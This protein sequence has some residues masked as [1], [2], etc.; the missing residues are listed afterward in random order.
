MFGRDN[1]RTFKRVAQSASNFQLQIR[2]ATPSL[3]VRF[4]RVA[5]H[6]IASIASISSGKNPTTAADLKRHAPRSQHNPTKSYDAT[7]TPRPAPNAEP[8]ASASASSTT[9]TAASNSPYLDALM[10]KL[11]PYA[12]YKARS[13][14]TSKNSHIPLLQSHLAAHRSDGPKIVLLG[15]SMFERMITTGRT[16]NFPSRWPSEAMQ[17]D[18]HGRLAAFPNQEDRRLRGIF[19]AGVGGDKVQ[20]VIYRL[21]GD[22]ERGLLPLLPIL[23]PSVKV[24]VV[25]AGGNNLTPRTGWSEQDQ[26]MVR[27]LAKTLLAV[28][29]GNRVVLTQMFYRKDVPGEIVDN[30]NARIK[31][32]AEQLREAGFGDTVDC[33]GPPRRFRVKK[34]LQDQAHLNLQGYRVWTEQLLMQFRSFLRPPGARGD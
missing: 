25:H 8:T 6:S 1:A 14:N 4:G 20:N 12:R 19:N 3:A 10:A 23:A 16:P 11:R 13:Y 9:D 15:D 33:W 27:E 30:T 34:H 21:V 22:E 28:N 24:W 17:P 29:P 7:T 2:Q 31:G 32:I 26:D 18:T 5:N